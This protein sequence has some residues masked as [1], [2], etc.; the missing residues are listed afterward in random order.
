MSALHIRRGDYALGATRIRAEGLVGGFGWRYWLGQDMAQ[1]CENNCEE[2]SVNV[3]AESIV[4]CYWNL[5]SYLPNKKDV[6]ARFNN[7]V[8]CGTYSQSGDVFLSACQG[9]SKPVRRWLVLWWLVLR[10]LVLWW[11]VLRW[12]V[13]GCLIST[14]VRSSLVTLC[15]I[16]HVVCHQSVGHW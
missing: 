12:L 5:F 7:K 1:A 16:W 6:K 9:M 4:E 13:L 11:L 10:W 2:V 3:V 15:L 8:F 14:H